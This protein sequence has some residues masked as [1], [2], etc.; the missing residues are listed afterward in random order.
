MSYSPSA[1]LSHRKLWQGASSNPKAHPPKCTPRLMPRDQFA[2]CR[3]LQSIRDSAV[4]HA[5]HSFSS[6]SRPARP[7]IPSTSHPA[8]VTKSSISLPETLPSLPIQPVSVCALEPHTNFPHTAPISAS[9]S[10]ERCIWSSQIAPNDKDS[11]VLN[12]KLQHEEGAGPSEE[13]IAFESELYRE[14]DEM[15]DIS[16]FREEDDKEN[17]PHNSET[18]DPWANLF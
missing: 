8:S 2:I 18:F 15:D 1:S 3:P 9:G 5:F 17:R 16:I 14:V 13:C 6:A 4:T 12:E 11:R 7:A 10:L